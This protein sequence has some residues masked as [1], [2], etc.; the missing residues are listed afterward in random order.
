MESRKMVLINRFA[1]LEQQYRLGEQT[2]DMAGEGEGGTN[3]ESSIDMY[4]LPCVKQ[5]ARGKPQCSTESPAWCS[6]ET[7]RA[8]I[9]GQRE[10]QEGEDTY[11]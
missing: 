5:R 11:V 3:G 10:S 9:A 8:D 7:Q 2:L 6:A 1:G 4:T